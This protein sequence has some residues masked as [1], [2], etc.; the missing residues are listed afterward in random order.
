MIQPVLLAQDRIEAAAADASPSLSR[1]GRWMST[2]PIRT[3]SHSAD[4]IASLS[5][6][7]VMPS[8]AVGALAVIEAMA[9][10]VMRLNPDSVRI[11]RE[12]AG[13]AGIPLHESARSQD[14]KPAPPAL[15][16]LASIL[17]QNLLS[18]HPRAVA[19]RGYLGSRRVPEA[20][21]SQL[22]IGAWTDAGAVG[23]SLRAARLS[24]G[25][26]REH[27][28]LARYVPSHPLLFLYEDADGVTGFKCRKP[29]LG[30]KSVLNALGFGGTV[31][32]RSLFGISIARKAITRYGRAI[33][34]EGEFDGLVW[35]AASLA[36]G[37]SLELVALGGSAKPTVA[38]FET[39]RSLGA[40]V[41]Y[42]AL[43]ADPA[44][45]ASTATVCCCALEAGLDVAV[46]RMPAGCKDPDEV[47][48]RHGSTEGARLLFALDRAEPAAAW[49]ARYQLRRFPPVT[50]EQATAF[51]E[52]SAEAARLMPVSARARYGE[53]IAEALGVPARILEAEWECH[54][55]TARARDMRDRLHRWA[56]DWVG[57]LEQASLAE[58]LDEASTL[59]R[60]ARAI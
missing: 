20:V 1:V 34:V 12:L 29:V 55:A 14:A 4:E 38:K 19:C 18:D 3:L 23:G 56:L 31:E 48:S 27:G 13:R 10:A 43:D 42:L 9:V 36:V 32:G 46:L 54:A 16:I 52:A 41:V 15:A 50:V 5:T 40:R 7:P 17:K 37:R 6:H 11:A 59:L 60:A 25:P 28:L 2:H 30:E 45:E 21:I 26:L 8:S 39:L 49:L 35:Y 51:R 57:R 58:H 33:V 53:I 47:L 44:G 24:A 22:P